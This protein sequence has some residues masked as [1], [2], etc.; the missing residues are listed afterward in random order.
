MLREVLLYPDTVSL[1]GDARMAVVH[2]SEDEGIVFRKRED[3]PGI[4]ALADLELD[5]G[6]H[7]FGLALRRA[8]GIVN[9]AA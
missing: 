1:V 4:F 3:F 5:F 6:T 2:A 9:R 7:G 8:V